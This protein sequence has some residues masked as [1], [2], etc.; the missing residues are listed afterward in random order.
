MLE[1][2]LVASRNSAIGTAQPIPANVRAALTGY[3]EPDILNR[4]RY[5]VGDSGI[6]NLAGLTIAYGDKLT[7]NQAAAVALIDLVVFRHASDAASNLSLWAHEL[8]HIKQFRDWG[9][10]DFA[11]RYARDSNAVERQAEAVGDNYGN[12]RAQQAAAALAANRSR[13]PPPLTAG[14][15]GLPPGTPMLQCGCYAPNSPQFA[16]EARCISRAVQAVA[17]PGMCGGGGVPFGY[18]CR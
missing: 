4:V 7:G 3:I 11:K 1:Q 8:E 12:W 18:V 14:P 15:V 13:E 9:V 2:W 5:K 10:G 6:L 16:P 17:C